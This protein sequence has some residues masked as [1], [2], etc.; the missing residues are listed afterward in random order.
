MKRVMLFFFMLITPMMDAMAIDALP[1]NPY[2]D[3]YDE[4]E[5]LEIV[6]LYPKID[7]LYNN[8]VQARSRE[9]SLANRMLGAV[10]IGA[11]G[12]GGM[13]LGT[14]LAEQSA[15]AAAERDMTAYIATFR[16]DYGMGRNIDG[17]STGITLPSIDISAL[18]SEYIS[19]ASDIKQ[20]KASLGLAPGLESDVIDV[21]ANAG[22]YDNVS[23]GVTGGA[24]TSV[25]RAL[26]DTDGTD[27]AKWNEQKSQN[28]DN[29]QTGG[30]TLGVGSVGGAVG[31]ILING[32]GG[33]PGTDD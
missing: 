4:T 13:M 14:A 2:A 10:A 3:L 9:Q 28:S 30:I 20:R 19:L 21:A 11:G 17:G 32:I 12:I 24:Y 8:Y 23:T 1:Q 7:E 15:S 31:N 16:C 27:A 5:M 25:Y 29:L 33:N 18:R 22:L 26:T 6:S